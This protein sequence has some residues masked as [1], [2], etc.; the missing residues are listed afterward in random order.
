MGIFAGLKST[1]VKNELIKTIQAV[2]IDSILTA[3]YKL[4]DAQ[5]TYND[6]REV[7]VEIAKLLDRVT[8]KLLEK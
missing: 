4:L 8:T 7:K 2:D 5:L 6:K 1:V 3:L